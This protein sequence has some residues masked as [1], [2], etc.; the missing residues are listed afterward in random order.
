MK[1][2]HVPGGWITAEYSKLPYSTLTRRP[3][4]VNKGKLDGRR[5]EIQRL[6]GRALRVAIDLDPLGERTLWGDCDLLEADVDTRPAP[7]TGGQV[8]I[9]L[10]SAKSLA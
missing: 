2:H 6:I 1:D 4:G 5:V 7:P 10:A 9:P 8:P 3:R